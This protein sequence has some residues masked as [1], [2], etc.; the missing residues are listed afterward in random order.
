[1]VVATAGYF[2]VVDTA[3]ALESQPLNI[4]RLI[5]RK[6]L[7]ASRIGPTGPYRV[8][9]SDLAAYIKNGCSDLASPKIDSSGWIL[10]PFHYLKDSFANA[11]RNAAADQV[12]PL[13]EVQK[14]FKDAKYPDAIT[15]PLKVTPAIQKVLDSPPIYGGW[16]QTS[17][18]RIKTF[19]DYSW[20]GC[21]FAVMLRDAAERLLRKNLNMAPASNLYSSPEQ[22]KEITDQARAQVLQAKISFS[23]FHNLKVPVGVNSNPRAVYYILG[24]DQILGGIGAQ[25]MVNE[26]F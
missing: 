21:Y 8:A 5:A 25:R 17:G 10:T 22:Y 16:A 7:P 12:L 24:N 18:D 26:A 1:M 19:L 14:L 13:K 2:S 15:V 11:V 4:Q 20:L 3:A 23:T 6:V 9:E